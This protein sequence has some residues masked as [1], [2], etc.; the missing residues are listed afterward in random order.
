MKIPARLLGLL[1]ASLAA[2]IVAGCAADTQT[3]E[4]PETAERRAE[5][6]QSS[7]PESQTNAPAPT[8]PTTTEHAATTSSTKPPPETAD[9]GAPDAEP[10]PYEDPCPPCG[11]G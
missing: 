8:V 7:T 3:P 4:T 6:G 5:L 2:P 1:A 10:P 9:A 11:Q